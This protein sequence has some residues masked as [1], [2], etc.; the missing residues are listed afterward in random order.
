MLLVNKLKKYG[1]SKSLSIFIKKK[2]NIEIMKFHYLKLKIDIKKLDNLLFNFDLQVKELKIEDF[3]LGNPDVFNNNKLKLINNRLN[4][5]NYRAY[6][7]IENN[8]LIYST[9]VSLK[10]I[11]LP[12]I[13]KQYDLLSDEGLLEDSYCDVTAR[14]RGLHT[15]MNYF[16][17]KRLHEFGKKQI[18]AIVLDGNDAAFKTQFK[19]GFTRLGS[20]YCGKILGVEFCQLKK[21]KYDNW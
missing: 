21:E 18:V 7:I 17:I 9:W 2:F 10:K 14:G 4:D 5:E 1:L 3:L 11:S 16:R 19:S 15:Q 12:V 13:S 20:F 8:K 6:G